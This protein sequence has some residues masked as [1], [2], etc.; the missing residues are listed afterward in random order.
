[1]VVNYRWDVFGHFHVFLRNYGCQNNNTLYIVTR[2]YLLGEWMIWFLCNQCVYIY[3]TNRINVS[4]FIL[5]GNKNGSFLDRV[6]VD[7]ILRLFRWSG[8][9]CA[10][11][12]SGKKSQCVDVLVVLG[13]SLHINI[14]FYEYCPTQI[15]HLLTVDVLEVSVPKLILVQFSF[16][17]R[18]ILCNY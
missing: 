2:E 6:L 11:F 5:D 13:C 3:T 15:S 18:S 7:K 9:C 16:F 8:R 17:G 14:C 10:S 12:L 1:M 4:I